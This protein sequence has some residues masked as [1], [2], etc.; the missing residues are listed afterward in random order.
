MKSSMKICGFWLVSN[1]EIS[2]TLPRA[3]FWSDKE[4]YMLN[5]HIHVFNLFKSWSNL[6]FDQDS[7][8]HKNSKKIKRMKNQST[9]IAFLCHIY[10]KHSKVDK[11]GLASHIQIRQIMYLPL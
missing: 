9:Y 11:Q 4:G 8:G 5:F 6:G 2:K 7:N 3:S 1:M 10:S